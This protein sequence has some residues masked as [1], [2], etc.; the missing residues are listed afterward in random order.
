[1]CVCLCSRQASSTAEGFPWGRYRGSS[2]QGKDSEEA[3][4]SS[5]HWTTCSTAHS[6]PCPRWPCHRSVHCSLCQIGVNVWKLWTQHAI[7]YLH[8]VSLLILFH[9]V[10]VWK[11]VWHFMS[12]NFMLFLKSVLSQSECL[13]VKVLFYHHLCLQISTV[14]CRKLCI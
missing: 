1:M 8:T 7:Y 4:W 10:L 14:M 13:S 2:D 6:H 12:Y 9:Y 11:H 5:L 3:C